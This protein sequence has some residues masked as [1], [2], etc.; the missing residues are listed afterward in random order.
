MKLNSQ[1]FPHYRC[2]DARRCA[3]DT[4]YIALPYHLFCFQ[5]KMLCFPAEIPA[6]LTY[7]GQVLHYLGLVA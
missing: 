4:K 1:Y 5:M 2:Y 7:V 6:E 3:L